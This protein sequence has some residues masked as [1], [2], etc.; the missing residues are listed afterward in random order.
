[1]LWYAWTAILLSGATARATEQPTD[2]YVQSDAN[3]AAHP[4]KGNAMWIAFHQ[5]EGVARIVDE[6][7]GLSES[8]PRISDIFKN[9]DL[10]RLRRILKE[11]LCYILNGGCHYTGRTMQAAHKDMG[12]QTADLGAFVEH[13]QTAM[14]N[15]NVS[16][17]A[18]NRLL[19]KLAPI[20][21]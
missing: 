5:T 19:A 21:V 2:P 4:F 11:Q 6:A 9:R 14:G 13:L 20:E 3:A 18:K 8:D 12:I 1:M 7:I 10:V 15:E 16:I 17:W